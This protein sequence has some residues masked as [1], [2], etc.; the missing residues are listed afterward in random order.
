MRKDKLKWAIH[1]K[2]KLKMK[3]DKIKND[4]LEILRQDMVP[5]FM[6]RSKSTN[7]IAGNKANQVLHAKEKPNDI[8]SG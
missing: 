6:S 5:E 8:Y 2:N 7:D 1:S 3:K 4:K